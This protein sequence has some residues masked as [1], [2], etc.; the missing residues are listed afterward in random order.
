MIAATAIAT[1]LANAGHTVTFQTELL[2]HQVLENHPHIAKV[3][4]PNSRKPDIDLSDINIPQRTLHL[5]EAF[6]NIAK[7][8]VPMGFPLIRPVIKILD[9]EKDQFRAWLEKH[10]R[11]WIF[12]CP[13][14]WQA[15]NRVV[16]PTVLREVFDAYPHGTF[17]NPTTTPMG[18]KS[19]YVGNG[20]FRGLMACLSLADA[21]VTVDSGPMHVA[22]CLGVPMVVVEQAWPIYLRIP[23]G[24]VYE[25]V[26]CNLPCSP[27][28]EHVCRLAGVNPDF[29]PCQ[30][31]NAASILDA[32]YRL[33]LPERGYSP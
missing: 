12:V 13:G 7:K 30:N 28:R 16:K 18:G 26:S 3:E 22:A 24:A 4:F 10:P 29:P 1:H 14:S 32:L 25:Q 21:L 20:T 17:I 5:Q 33:R 19:I 15:M 6:G 27:C 11:P 2:C 8:T 9:R 31:V 23:P